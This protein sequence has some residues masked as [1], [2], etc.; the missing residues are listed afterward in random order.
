MFTNVD[1]ASTAIKEAVDDGTRILAYGDY[2]VDGACSVAISRAFFKYINYENFEIVSYTKRTHHVDPNI[3]IQ[4]LT[5]NV[6]LII[7]S[8]TGSGATDKKEIERLAKIS[9][10]VVADHH[11]AKY[12]LD[13]MENVIFVNPTHFDDFKG[14]SGAC[15]TYEIYKDYIMK[16]RE[17]D[18]QDFV[19]RTVFY[20]FMS[21]YSDSVYSDNSYCRQIHKDAQTAELPQEFNYLKHYSP[22][23][24]FALFS[25]AP[26]L[27]TCFRNENFDII[28]TLM[29][30]RKEIP[31]SDKQILVDRMEELRNASRKLVNLITRQ[32]RYKEIGEFILVDLTGYLNQSVPNH[33][34]WNNKGL[35]AGQLAGREKKC[36]I[37][38]ISKGDHYLLSCRDFWG[39]DILS[40]MEPF[41]KVGGHSSA[42]GGYLEISDLFLLED[43]L[44][45]KTFLGEAKDERVIRRFNTLLP[46]D[47]QKMAYNNE[48][49]KEN[50]LYI[51]DVPF[52]HF[53]VG[54]SP[55]RF[56]EQ[57]E[58]LILTLPDRR[59]V[60]IP[61]EDWSKQSSSLKVALYI[62][63][64]LRG[65]LVK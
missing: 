46:E 24:R 20:P 51:V 12:D 54:K 11:I 26:P 34:L 58:N 53:Q 63:N 59:K 14:A 25:F 45:S 13:N 9:K 31:F 21:L 27:N 64:G 42:F 41:F 32:A 5:K 60:Y 48:F 22:S 19:K 17:S 37:S 39:R 10:V 56:S 62:T 44:A 30:S 52:S 65:V 6:G 28:N 2:D 61:R 1:R 4:A 33:V 50:N 57:Y 8:D 7:I 49:R 18:T 36:V 47:F 16:Y 15:V 38:V 40:L 55:E 23:K 35:I 29:F 3:L 43:V